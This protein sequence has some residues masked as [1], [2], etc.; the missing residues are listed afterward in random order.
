MAIQLKNIKNLKKGMEEYSKDPL[1]QI[2]IAKWSSLGGLIGL[3]IAFVAMIWTL[4]IHWDWRT[5]GICVF[6]SFTLPSLY[7]QY[8]SS[9]DKIKE[10][11]AA[12]PAVDFGEALQSGENDPDM[13]D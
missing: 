12:M 2:T 10:A 5:F 8:V 13:E 3:G 7:S 1:G 4:I 6:I 9:R 11:K